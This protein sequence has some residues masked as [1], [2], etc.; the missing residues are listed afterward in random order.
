[1]V[2]WVKIST[3]KLRIENTNN[4]SKNKNTVKLTF[5]S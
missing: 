2:K 3:K 1:M 5:Y 4:E